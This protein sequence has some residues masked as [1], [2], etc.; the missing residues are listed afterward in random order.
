MIVVTASTL[1]IDAYV[2]IV[3]IVDWEESCIKFVDDFC[4]KVGS[5]SLTIDVAPVLVFL[6]LV[7]S[8]LVAIDDKHHHCDKDDD[9][10][11]C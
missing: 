7:L 8:E 10:H 11:D 6:L 3:W 5:T 9:R 1:G 2:F 4:L